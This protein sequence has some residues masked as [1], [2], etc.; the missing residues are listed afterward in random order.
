VPGRISFLWQRQRSSFRSDSTAQTGS[1]TPGKASTAPISALYLDGT[2]GTTPASK[3]RTTTI[4]RAYLSTTLLASSSPI[5]NGIA[6]A[7]IRARRAGYDWFPA[8]DGQEDRLALLMGM[9]ES[10]AGTRTQ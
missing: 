8:D 4:R 10:F 1:V 5:S 2:A 9:D 3:T 7:S 6:G